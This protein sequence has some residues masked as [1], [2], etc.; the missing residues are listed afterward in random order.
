MSVAQNLRHNS[1]WT[2]T[3]LLSI[4]IE[5]KPYFNLILPTSYKHLDLLHFFSNGYDKC[6]SEEFL[7]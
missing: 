5:N 6:K 1:N 3:G 7:L 2:T 4:N